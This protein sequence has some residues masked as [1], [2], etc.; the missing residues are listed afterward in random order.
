[1]IDHLGLVQAD[2][3][4]RERVVKGQSPTVLTDGMIPAS[5]FV[6][7]YRMDRYSLPPSLWW[8]SPATFTSCRAR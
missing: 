3:R 8:S 6:V 7:P 2:D 5:A 1:V 4:L